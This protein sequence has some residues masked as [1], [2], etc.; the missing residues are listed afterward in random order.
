MTLLKGKYIIGSGSR[1]AGFISTINLGTKNPP[2]TDSF[3]DIDPL[4]FKVKETNILQSFYRL[5]EKEKKTGQS[6]DE[7]QADSD[8]NWKIDDHGAFDLF[9]NLE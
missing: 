5:S 3:H 2:L 8:S 4:I 6:F 7:E 9:N 1:V